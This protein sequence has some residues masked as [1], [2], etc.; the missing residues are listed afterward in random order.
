MRLKQ[1][2]G[3]A[4]GAPS[5]SLILCWVQY[6][7]S[8][9]SL[10]SASLM[11]LGVRLVRLL[12]GSFSQ[13]HEGVMMFEV[14]SNLQGYWVLL[15]Q[16]GT[17]PLITRTSVGNS[18]SLRFPKTLRVWYRTGYLS[19]DLGPCHIIVLAQLDRKYGGRVGGTNRS[20]R[21][22]LRDPGP[23]A[24]SSTSHPGLKEP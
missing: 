17:S 13:L 19:P 7:S 18:D 21:V 12:Q 8:S 22:T 24:S 4:T 9:W 6:L 2:N 3:S 11:A 20:C 23:A 16:T 14:L 15:V 10:E 1:E 5:P